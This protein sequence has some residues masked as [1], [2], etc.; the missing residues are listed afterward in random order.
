MAFCIDFCSEV[1]QLGN[2]RN[3]K[4]GGPAVLA[5]FA[6]RV[7]SMRCLVSREER[8]AKLGVTCYDHRWRCP[9]R[10]SHQKRMNLAHK[11]DVESEY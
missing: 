1:L 4:D 9:R 5:H 6:A 11:A 2:L 7:D 8:I 10:T 3:I